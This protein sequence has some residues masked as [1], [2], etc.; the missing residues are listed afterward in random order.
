[1]R[2]KGE[3]RSKSR[4]REVSMSIILPPPPSTFPHLLSSLGTSAFRL[5]PGGAARGLRVMLSVG[6][7]MISSSLILR[8]FLFVFLPFFS[9]RSTL[10]T[11]QCSWIRSR[12]KRWLGI[13]KAEGFPAASLSLAA[14]VC[15]REEPPLLNCSSPSLRYPFSY[16]ALPHKHLHVQLSLSFNLVS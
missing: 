13:D 10:G 1:M 15:S 14:S 16:S 3:G 11:F 6:K 12:Y 7:N 4:K 2:R 9:T 5:E 8:L